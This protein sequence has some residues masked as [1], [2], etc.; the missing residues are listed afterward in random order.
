MTYSYGTD[1]R[2]VR[3]P[4]LRW[5]DARNVGFK[6]LYYLR[7]SLFEVYILATHSVNWPGREREGVHNLDTSCGQSITCK[8]DKSSD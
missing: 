3:L 4:L 7:L 8:I 6:C 5:P 2:I 1:P